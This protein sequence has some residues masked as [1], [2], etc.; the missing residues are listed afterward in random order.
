[1]ELDRELAGALELQGHR[2]RLAFLQRTLDVDEHQMRA[3]RPELHRAPGR[4]VVALDLP[5]AQD[6]AVLDVDVRLDLRRGRRGA[7]DEAIGLRRF[8]A[9]G[10]VAGGAF[11]TRRRGADPGLFDLYLRPGSVGEQCE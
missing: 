5:H 8:V 1:V 7:A 9:H 10:H 6:L 4:D 2:N 11:R 3:A